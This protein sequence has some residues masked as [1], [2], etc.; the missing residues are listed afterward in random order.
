MFQ[1]GNPF[2]QAKNSNFPKLLRQYLLWQLGAGQW[3]HP[4]FSQQLQLPV[5]GNTEVAQGVRVYTWN[6]VHTISFVIVLL[7]IINQRPCVRTSML[8]LYK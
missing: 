8:I 7:I 6:S 4:A 5:L 3:T 2:I 1:N